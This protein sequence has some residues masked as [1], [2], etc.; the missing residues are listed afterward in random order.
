MS[1]TYAYSEYGQMFAISSDLHVTRCLFLHSEYVVINII[2]ESLPYQVRVCAT[3]VQSWAKEY[4]KYSD[5][6]GTA[7]VPKFR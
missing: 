7:R 6:Q 1:V 2:T 4:C 3:G 5:G